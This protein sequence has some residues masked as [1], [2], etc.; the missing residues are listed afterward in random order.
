MVKVESSKTFEFVPFEIKVSIKVETMEQMVN[1]YEDVKKALD[2][3]G[4]VTDE[5]EDLMKGLRDNL[6]V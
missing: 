1:M 5:I 2:D 6:K 3:W 4:Y